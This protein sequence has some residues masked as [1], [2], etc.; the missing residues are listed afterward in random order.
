MLKYLFAFIL[1]VHGL[2][3]FMGFAKAI[4]YGNMTRL[5]LDISKQAGFIW[6]VAALLFITATILFLIKMDVWSLI[7]IVAALLSQVLIVTVWKDAKVGTLANLIV[8]LVAIPAY[9]D[10]HFN[11]V[12]KKE[13][14]DL[15][16]RPAIANTIVT[17]AMTDSLPPIVQKW[18][19]NSGV[20]GKDKIQFVRL[21]QKGEL[22]TKPGGKW[23]PFTATQYFT[24]NEPQFIWQT[25]MKMMPMIDVTGRDKFV[26]GKGEMTIK[27][28]SLVNL[29][30]ARDDEKL[31][32]ATM[33]RYLAETTWFPSAALN[34]YIR[35]EALSSTSAKAIMTYKGITVSGIMKFA[36]NGDF[37][38]F[39]A[40]RYK[41]TGKNAS[42]EKW[43]VE[44]IAYKDFNGIRIPHKSKV[45]WKLKEGDFNWA[46]MELTDIEYNNPGLY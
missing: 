34:D 25:K 1:L 26:N 43:L 44:T 8:L 39:E 46:T 40:D 7:A 21:K 27:L 35:W 16:S 6:F 17:N 11:R 3:H 42:L 28:L 13:V 5:T 45:T 32:S 20:I 10:H 18:L 30:N 38:S 15:L 23:L 2:I 24:V 4:S 36:E 19:A 37:L 31:N 22:R 33:I 41:D 29:A 9:A 12:V 14:A